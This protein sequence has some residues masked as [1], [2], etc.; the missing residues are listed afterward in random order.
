MSS[1]LSSDPNLIEVGLGE[2]VGTVFQALSMMIS[3]FVIASTKNWKLALATFCVIPYT[4]FVTGLLSS[5][6]AKIESKV[7]NLYSESSTLAEEALNSPTT[8]VSLG[9]VEKI[10]KKYKIFVKNAS[11]VSLWTGPLQACTYGNLWFAIQS[12]YALALFYGAHL[13]AWGDIEKGGTVLTYSLVP[14]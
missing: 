5:I 14:Y 11:S 1:S 13:V 4:I 3:S 12:V 6:D 2:K 9:A 10:V 8:I 7:R